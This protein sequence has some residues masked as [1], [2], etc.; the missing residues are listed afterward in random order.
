MPH[1]RFTRRAAIRRGLA[2]GTGAALATGAAGRALAQSTPQASPAPPTGPG[3]LVDAAWLRDHAGDPSL[4]IVAFGP[5]AEAEEP[6]IP[7]A[8]PVDWPELELADSTETAITA[9]HG[10]VMGLI[11]D[12]GITADSD[13]VVYDNGTLFAARL[14]WILRYLGHERVTILDGGLPAWQAAGLDTDSGPII[15]TM[16]KHPPYDGTPD[17]GRLATI[18]EVLGALDDPETSIVD[19]RTPE[20][21]AKAHIPGAVNVN[22]PRNAANAPP[23]T[24]LSADDLRAMYE[25]LGVTPD[26][27]VIPYCSTGVR[28]AVTAHALHHAGWE[29]VALYSASW[30]EWGASPDT[31][32]TEGDQP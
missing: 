5:A 22:Y 25:E 18:D 21:Y 20:E 3:A 8:L 15:R 16:I 29:R 19:A 10:T 7:G 14:W 9:W 31:P 30:Q 28:S 32:K 23:L 6:R 4:V 17:A 11:G 13:V 26:Q 27:L 2:A 12:V 24:Y 1:H